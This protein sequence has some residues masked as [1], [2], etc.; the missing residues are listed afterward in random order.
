[1]HAD[2]AVTK[3][4]YLILVACTLRYIA[5]ICRCFRHRVSFNNHYTIHKSCFGHVYIAWK[6]L[7]LH[8]FQRPAR[9]KSMH[10]DRNKR[11]YRYSITPVLYNSC[12]HAEPYRPIYDSIN[13]VAVAWLT[14]VVE[15]F[16][17][18]QLF[19]THIARG[20]W[21]HDAYFRERQYSTFLVL[22]FMIGIY[23]WAC[24]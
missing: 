11:L 17:I 14:S 24:V 20:I 1:M 2:I 4:L 3:T 6:W 12:R 16:Q 15:S 22:C 18:S 23:V 13:L 9:S 8:G 5:I 7:H 21:Y 10:L 19:F